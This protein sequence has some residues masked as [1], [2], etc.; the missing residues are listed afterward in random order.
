MKK[1]TKLFIA[2]L[3]LVALGISGYHV[4]PLVQ[5]EIDRWRH[6]IH[7]EEYVMAAA[8]QHDIEPARI[9]A[10][11]LAESGFR[12]D[13]V[14]RAEAKGLMQFMPATFE[15][16]VRLRGLDYDA[17]DVFTPSVNIDFGAFYL[18]FLYNQLGDWDHVHMAY[19]A[20]LSNVQAWLG[21]PELLENGRIVHELIPFGETR[22][23]IQRVNNAIS[24]YRRLYFDE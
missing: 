3:L 16:L 4:F 19:N 6:P 18:R 1:L 8:R 2:I 23:Y 9:F 14:S 5:R 21:R 12:Y 13:A 24:E 7:Y 11:I 20:G 17:D 22:R 15:W 10:V